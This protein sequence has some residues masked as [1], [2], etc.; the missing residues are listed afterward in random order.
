MTTNLRTER[1]RVHYNARIET[2]LTKIGY[3][4]QIAHMGLE[5]CI[6]AGIYLV[7]G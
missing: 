4:W 2:K 6:N 3:F 5:K 1:K 7:R